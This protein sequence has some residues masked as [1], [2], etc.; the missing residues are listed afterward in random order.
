MAQSVETV[1]D[2][3]PDGARF[4]SGSCCGTPTTLLAALAQRAAGRAWSLR[5]G[6]LLADDGGVLAA[7]DTGTLDVATWHVSAPARG[8]VERGTLDYVPLRASHVE[9]HIPAWGIDVALVRVTPPDRYGLC[10]LGPSVSYARTAIRSARTCIAEVDPSLPRTCGEST[11]HADELDVIV[12]SSI[13][14]PT[15]APPEPDATSVAIADHV[16][17]LLP[18]RPVLQLGIGAVP[19]AL[20]AALVAARRGG[21]RFVGMGVDGMADLAELGLLDDRR[22][23]LSSPDLLGTE[24]L[25]RFAHEN[26]AVGVFPSTIAHS[27]PRLAAHERLVSL[28]SAVEIDLSGQ[29]NSEVAAG[30]QIAGVGGSIDFVEAAGGS[31]DGVRIVALPSTTRDGARNRIVPA[32]GPGAVVT[33]PRA[34]VDVVVTEH[35]VARLEGASLR[36]RAEALVGIAAPQHRE[37]L[38][39]SLRE[40]VAR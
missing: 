1:L 21:L 32:L 15:Y 12:E 34:M 36:E 31:V 17:A 9:R 20:V 19:E 30:R 40:P 27:P 25:M 28:L 22:P 16:V 37:Q 13:P 5:S 26:P 11:V 24:R 7:A 23:A 6:L 38:E 10:S 29:V 3:V 2:R 14:A 35:G 8:M 33:V 4:I 18:D 39:A